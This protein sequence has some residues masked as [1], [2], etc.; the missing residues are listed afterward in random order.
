MRQIVK[1]TCVNSTHLIQ[2]HFIHFIILIMKSRRLNGYYL[3]DLLPSAVPRVS[4]QPPIHTGSVSCVYCTE[5]RPFDRI[6]LIPLGL[7]TMKYLKK[8]YL[9]DIVIFFGMLVNAVVIALILAYYVF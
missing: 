5:S 2:A 1:L 6:H 9:S 7:R 3:L 4:S 8:K